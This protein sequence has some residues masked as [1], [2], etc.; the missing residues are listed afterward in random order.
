MN[1]SR[2]IQ[3]SVL[4]NP[5]INDP[6]AL[7]A[8]IVQS[9]HEWHQRNPQARGAL[10]EN[11]RIF[12]LDHGD[13]AVEALEYNIFLH[14]YEKL[15]PLYC[16]PQAYAAYLRENVDGAA[17]LDTLHAAQAASEA[18]LVATG[19]FGAVEILAP[20]FAL[21]GMTVSAVLRFTTPQF[22]AAAFQQAQRLIKSG[23]FSPMHF[24]EIGKPGVAAALEMAAVIR[25][26]E[27]LITVF[28]ERTEYSI[29]A[30]LFGRR[31]W[32]GAG[33]DRLMKFAGAP[34]RLFA[35]FMVRI[36]DERYF[37]DTTIVPT[38]CAAPIQQLFDM[39]ASNIRRHPEQWYLMHEEVDL[40]EERPVA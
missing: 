35:A 18:C 38:G 37:L 3:N 19:H 9:G 20:Y 36:G 16:T 13:A 7:K 22:S 24:I 39:M 30:D 32:G 40:V 27:V 6:Y 5:R 21:H 11:L 33:I 8:A 17:G 15:L 25:R 26:G 23:S 34:H 2:Y 4:N 31:V 28:D 12:G 1:L 14:Y 29:P 10:A